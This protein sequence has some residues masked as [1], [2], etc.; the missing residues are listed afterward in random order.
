[1][2]RVPDDLVDFAPD[3][4]SKPR[5][6]KPYVL[7]IDPKFYDKFRIAEW[8]AS[9]SVQADWT[10]SNRESIG[11]EFLVLETREKFVD[12]YTLYGITEAPGKILANRMQMPVTDRGLTLKGDIGFFEIE[13]RWR[14]KNNFHSFSFDKQGVAIYNEAQ[15][16]HYV[17]PTYDPTQVDLD[18]SVG[19]VTRNTLNK[20]ALIYN[21]T[22][23]SLV[24][25]CEK[26]EKAYICCSHSTTV[27]IAES[28]TSELKKCFFVK[29]QRV[30]DHNFQAATDLVK[31]ACG[32]KCPP[33]LQCLTDPAEFVRLITPPIITQ[34]QSPWWGEY[35]LMA[36]E[37]ANWIQRTVEVEQPV[38]QGEASTIPLALGAELRFMTQNPTPRLI[39]DMLMDCTR[40]CDEA[41]STLL[42]LGKS[43]PERKMN[44][45]RS[46]H[47]MQLRIVYDTNRRAV[48]A[49]LESL[50]KDVPWTEVLSQ[51]DEP[52]RMPF[53]RELIALMH[54]ACIYTARATGKEI[55]I[56][57]GP[58]NSRIS[59]LAMLTGTTMSCHA[60]YEVMTRY[61]RKM[62]VFMMAIAGFYVKCG[63]KPYDRFNHAYALACELAATNDLVLALFDVQR[64]TRDIVT[65]KANKSAESCL[66]AGA[67]SQ[68][69]EFEVPNDISAWDDKPFDTPV[70]GG[71]TIAEFNNNY[72]N[73]W[74]KKYGVDNLETNKLV[75]ISGDDRINSYTVERRAL[76][77]RANKTFNR[78]FPLN[79]DGDTDDQLALVRYMYFESEHFP[80]VV[81][82]YEKMPDHFS[83]ESQEKFATMQSPVCMSKRQWIET[84]LIKDQKRS[85]Q[86]YG[87]ELSKWYEAVG[88]ETADKVARYEKLVLW[89]TFDD[90]DFFVPPG[91]SGPPFVL[92]NTWLRERKLAPKHFASTI[93]NRVKTCYGGENHGDRIEEDDRTQYFDVNEMQSPNMTL[94][95]I[96]VCEITDTPEKE[97]DKTVTPT[98]DTQEFVP[99]LSHKERRKLKGTS[100]KVDLLSTP[101]R[102]SLPSSTR[103]KVVKTDTQPISSLRFKSRKEIGLC[104][105]PN[106]GPYDRVKRRN[107][108]VA[109]AREIRRNSN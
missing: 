36:V 32:N 104:V 1:M 11:K 17:T 91:F 29:P 60:I 108:R 37:T 21:D 57:Y 106:P 70:A 92:M 62:Q 63:D 42:L 58:G 31:T 61:I 15:F 79:V 28:A 90:A 81:I 20:K 89:T 52:L 3:A 97:T 23:L 34:N 93:E 82:P 102:S 12:N 54:N 88:V 83:P 16:S 80:L 50:N 96:D 75:E 73:D 65:I 109:I 100:S 49:I 101:S 105:A 6:P 35:V 4:W 71:W 98:D 39:I 85:W 77:T 48:I 30:H 68:Y 41:A 84:E 38:R 78:N 64:A 43:N 9:A 46:H 66:N 86:T 53:P 107:H 18:M 95:I 33:N 72:S 2:L 13:S 74:L 59:D 8:R 5:E 27:R 103:P 44:H 94:Q 76:L 45:L 51:Y 40:N 10:V 24:K 67:V 56:P 25:W 87:Q 14:E 55:F 7:G 26:Q 47:K 22:P 99:V 69:Y 19:N